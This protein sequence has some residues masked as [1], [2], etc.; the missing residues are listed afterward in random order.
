[1]VSRRLM[2][3]QFPMAFVSPPLWTS[4]T[5]ECFHGWGTQ[6]LTLQMLY[7]SGQKKVSVTLPYRAVQPHGQFSALCVHVYKLKRSNYGHSSFISV[8]D[9]DYGILIL[10]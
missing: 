6:E 7:S 3:L 2:G 5:K 4:F 10:L 1:M 8:S 9:I